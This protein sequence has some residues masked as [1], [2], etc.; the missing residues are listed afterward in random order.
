MC[1]LL[2]ISLCDSAASARGK[3]AAM[4]GFIFL[5]SISGHISARNF[6]AILALASAERGRRV[7]PVMTNR[8]DVVVHEAGETVGAKQDAVTAP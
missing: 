3:R 1:L 5:L 7:D 8:D 6:S 4:I 2:S